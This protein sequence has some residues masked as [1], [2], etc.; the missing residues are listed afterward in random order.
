[1]TNA[2]AGTTLQALL[3]RAVAAIPSLSARGPATYRCPIA[4]PRL[5]RNHLPTLCREL[6]FTA[7]AEIGVWRGAYSA[8]FCEANP[9][10]QM[11]CVDP[12][13]SHAA[14]KDTKNKLDPAEAEAFM[15][16]SFADACT[17]LGAF[18]N[19]TIIRKFSAEAAHDVPDGS[20]DLVYV[21]G[22][23]VYDA[24]LEDLTLWAPKVRSGGLVSGH[25]YRRF[26]NKPFIHVVD[27]VNDYTKAHGIDPWFVL[28]A[29]KTPSF[30]WVVR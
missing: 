14:W 11:L 2:A 24:V 28:A 29:D 15:A 21:D 13:I 8:L 7:A 17:R 18:P 26:D 30:L 6:G 10:M 3:R 1:M 4:L 16:E 27:A 22:N 9:A 19:A 23:H 25:D 12:W 20:L 5:S